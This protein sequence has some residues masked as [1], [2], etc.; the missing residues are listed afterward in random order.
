MT[1]T[2]AGGPPSGG[3][4][5]TPRG[6]GVIQ[7]TGPS[8]ARTPRPTPRPRPPPGR[9]PPYAPGSRRCA[10]SAAA[11]GPRG[12]SRTYEDQRLPLHGARQPEPAHRLL[13]RPHRDDLLP[14]AVLVRRKPTRRSPCALTQT[15]M[16]SSRSA[17]TMTTAASPRT[18]AGAGQRAG[19]AMIDRRGQHVRREQ[20]QRARPCPPATGRAGRGAASGR[21]RR[22]A[23]RGRPPPR[24]KRGRPSGRAGARLILTQFHRM[25]CAR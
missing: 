5:A 12:R 4:R 6:P 10:W 21:G 11:A 13:H 18:R 2:R 25:G 3:V 1:T 22:T 24:Q 19:A 23:A 14:G 20:Q 17:Q 7:T 8:S 16:R 9:R 15:P